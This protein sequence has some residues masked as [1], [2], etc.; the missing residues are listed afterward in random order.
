MLTIDYIDRYMI[1]PV[2]CISNK[3]K[4][5]PA[6]KLAD[7]RWSNYDG[8]GRGYPFNQFLRDCYHYLGDL[9]FVVGIQQL[10]H[11]YYLQNGKLDAPTTAARIKIFL[12]ETSD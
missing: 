7:Y 11:Q 10:V 12:D 5:E 4:I 9:Q 8:W 2:G 1:H 6:P 3:A